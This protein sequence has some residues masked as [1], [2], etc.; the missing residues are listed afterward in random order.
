MGA[1]GLR[2]VWFLCGAVVAGRGWRW[3]NERRGRVGRRA[4]G[5]CF[6]V[7]PYHLVLPYDL[8]LSYRRRGR[9]SASLSG[10]AEPSE[11]VR[12]GSGGNEPLVRGMIQSTSL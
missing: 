11:R 5:H 9:R 8:G 6:E 1:G 7:L 4:A 10:C 12:N 3:R 2:C